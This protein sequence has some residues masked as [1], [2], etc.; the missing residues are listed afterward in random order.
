MSCPTRLNESNTEIETIKWIESMEGRDTHMH[1][2]NQNL[3]REP[4]PPIESKHKKESYSK[5]ESYPYRLFQD[6]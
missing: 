3:M 4:L 5:S 1:E 6:I 2:L